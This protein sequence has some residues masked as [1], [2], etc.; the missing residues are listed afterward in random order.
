VCLVDSD[1]RKYFLNILPLD[2]MTS[3]CVSLSV[4]VRVCV[5]VCA[6]VCVCVCDGALG[7]DR[8]FDPDAVFIY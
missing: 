5:C 6:C 8:V 7:A 4:C 2:L 3:V 1:V